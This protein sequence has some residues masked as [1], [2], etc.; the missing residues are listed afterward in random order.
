LA[1]IGSH[2]AHGLQKLGRKGG[3]AGKAQALAF[4]QRVADAKLAVVRD[5]DDVAGPGLFGQ[6]A[7]GGQEQDRVGDRHRLFRP[8]MQQLHAAF[9][10]ARGQADEGHA[11]AVLWVHVGL[12]L[13]D[14][15]GHRPLVGVDL[16]LG[17]LLRL[18]FGA[19]FADARPSVP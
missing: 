7:V 13:E 16:A 1:F 8:D 10:M 15:A 3:D 6:F 17:G 9:E 5:A 14:E 2:R 18:R 12:H 11:V 4:G 19:V